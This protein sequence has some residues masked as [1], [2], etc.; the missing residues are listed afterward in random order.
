[1]SQLIFSFHFYYESCLKVQKGKPRFS[2]LY[3]MLIQREEE[4]Q[5]LLL[6]GMS[7]VSP[8]M[9]KKFATIV[10]MGIIFSF[11]FKG[12]AMNE[13]IIRLCLRSLRNFFDESNFEFKP[14]L[15]VIST[16]FTDIDET[17]RQQIYT[18]YLDK[19]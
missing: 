7:Q 11:G 19:V 1:M 4:I 18:A 8:I 14:A 13:H 3:T 12:F 9:G 17:S 15:K 10:R 5:N 2:A 16:V 6:H